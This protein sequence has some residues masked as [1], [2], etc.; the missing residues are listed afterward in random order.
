VPFTGPLKRKRLTIELR[1]P[2]DARALKRLKDAL[3]KLLKQHNA[4]IRPAPR[5]A[6]RK[7]KSAAARRRKSR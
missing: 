4:A 3:T 7:K 2:A 6:A 1:G 5:A